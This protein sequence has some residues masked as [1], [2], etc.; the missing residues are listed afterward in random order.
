MATP[1]PA[2]SRDRGFLGGPYIFVGR[3][4]VTR[5]GRGSGRSMGWVGLLLNRRTAVAAPLTHFVE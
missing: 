4:A 5:H 1:P 2:E 3:G